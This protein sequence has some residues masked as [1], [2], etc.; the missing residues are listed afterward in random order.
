[1]LPSLLHTLRS[2]Q[3]SFGQDVDAA[4]GKLTAQQLYTSC[5]LAES[6]PL[7]RFAVNGKFRNSAIY[8]SPVD[9]FESKFM[10]LTGTQWSDRFNFVQQPGR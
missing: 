6:F 7:R 8:V 1:M 9:A 5:C 3:Q 2:R 4:V 10:G